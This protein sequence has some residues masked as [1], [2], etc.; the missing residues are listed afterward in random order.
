MSQ[1]FFKLI[2]K[3]QTQFLSVCMNNKTKDKN[4]KHGIMVD[5]QYRYL[6]SL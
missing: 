6:V 3:K 2:S 4:F 1:V 5:K